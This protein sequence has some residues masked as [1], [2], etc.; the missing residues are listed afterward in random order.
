M[1]A[2]LAPLA[3]IAAPAHAGE[4]YGV[5]LEVKTDADGVVTEVSVAEVL[6]PFRGKRHLK[7]PIAPEWVAAQRERIARLEHKHEAKTF[8]M[9][10][11][12][13]TASDNPAH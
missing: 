2:L 9:V 3:L 13:D 10:A 1:I 5:T 4:T 7:V 12:Y 11:F 8:Y 6:D